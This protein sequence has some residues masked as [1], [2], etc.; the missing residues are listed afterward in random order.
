M[1]APGKLSHLDEQGR[2]RMVDTSHKPVTRRVAE[3]ECTIEL[4]ASTVARLHALP[5][6]DAYAVA[7]IAGVQAAKRTAELVPLAHPLPL[8]LVEVTLEP[9]APG[10]DAPR[11]GVRVRSQVVVTAKTGAEMEAL[12]ACAGAALALY[13]MVKAVERQAVISGLRLLRK[14]G[15]KSGDWHAPPR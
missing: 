7:R 11:G 3:A 9:L 6:G 13:D 14:S 2:A 8:E 4:D 5:K 1:T 12:Y 10:G 15:G